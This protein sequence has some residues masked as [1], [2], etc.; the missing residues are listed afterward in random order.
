MAPLTGPDGQP[1][2]A[3]YGL[4]G[5]LLKI[6][7][8]VN[9][10]YIAAC[11]DRPE[12]TFREEQYKA[13]KATRPATDIELV[14]QLNQAREVF[15]QFK[16]KIFELAGF[17]A[18]DL[19]GTLAER[20]KSETDLQTIIISGDRDLLQLIDDDRVVIDLLRNGNAETARYNEARLKAEY[21]L[22]PAEFVE[23]KGL[24]GDPS[25]NIP[26]IKGVG[27]KT[28]TPLI[29]EFKTIDGI[30]ENLMIVPTKTAKKFEGHKDIALLSRQLATIKRDAPIFI[31]SL[32]DL[33]AMPIDTPALISYFQKLGFVSL[34]ERLRQTAD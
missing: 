11:F 18:D 4:S 25:D 10:D 22:T 23:L 16:I 12:P 7:R 21:G 28:A 30:Y 15:D 19:I 32:Q 17:E 5:L 14:P 29:Q 34:I 20:L 26:G 6:K 3:L 1:V 8:E 2:G 31:D 13:Y 24:I 33:C 27:I 9:P